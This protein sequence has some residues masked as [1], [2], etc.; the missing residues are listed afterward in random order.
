MNRRPN[1]ALVSILIMLALVAGCAGAYVNMKVED[2]GGMTAE[3]LVNNWQNY[4][5][6]YLGDFSIPYVVLFD[7]KDDGKTIKVADRWERVPSQADARRM[8]DM[9]STPGHGLNVPKLWKLL[10][11]DDSVFGYIYTKATML[12]TNMVDAQTMLVNY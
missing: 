10:G 9:I 8:V 7:P 1:I 11:P 5:V 4:N 6:Y 3:T 2:K 12:N